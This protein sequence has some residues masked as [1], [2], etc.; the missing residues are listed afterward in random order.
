MDC[1]GHEHALTPRHLM[2]SSA[3]ISVGAMLA[4]GVGPQGSTAAARAA[5]TASAALDVLRTGALSLAAGDQFELRPLVLDRYLRVVVEQ[6]LV[7]RTQLLDIETGK[8][9]APA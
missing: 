9:H 3:L 7:D 2:W 6:C 1:C 5:E 4:G 8:V